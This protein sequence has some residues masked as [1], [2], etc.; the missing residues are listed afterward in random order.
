MTEIEAFGRLKGMVAADADPVLTDGEVQQE[1][2]ANKV[3]DQDGNAPS[4]EAWTPTYNLNRAAAR[5][6]DVKAS[7]A[8]LY[9]TVESD[10]TAINSEQV[11]EHCLR[12][13]KEYRKRINYT[14]Q[15]RNSR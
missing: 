7:K 13:A 11:Y 3:A 14:I 12:M 1:L 6:W 8:V 2:D 4:R 15:M 10:G 9:V 5:L